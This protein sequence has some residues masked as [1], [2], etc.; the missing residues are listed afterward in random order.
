M[1]RL[2]KKEKRGGNLDGTQVSGSLSGT[3]IIANLSAIYNHTHLHNHVVM[4]TYL[5]VLYTCH[6]QR[7]AILPGYEACYL[8]RTPSELVE[9]HKLVER[10]RKL[11]LRVRL[12][13]FRTFKHFARIDSRN[14]RH[15]HEVL[16]NFQ[17]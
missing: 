9:R 6:Y 5:N 14:A 16:A 2:Q 11:K 17:E 8:N 12:R 10:H 15:T 3:Q 1:Q 13:G 7:D 4:L